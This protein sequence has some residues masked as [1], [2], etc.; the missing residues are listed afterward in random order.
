MIIL[1]VTGVLVGSVLGARFNVLVLIP[2]ICI[3]LVVV[4]VDSLGLGE[5]FWWVATTMCGFATALQLGY[6]LGGVVHFV[7]GA[8]RA[9]NPRRISMQRE[10]DRPKAA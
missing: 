4:L 8:A 10:G 2:V 1:T 3:A 9:P 6:L 7:V 5:G